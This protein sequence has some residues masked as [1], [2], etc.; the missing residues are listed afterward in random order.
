MFLEM[1]CIQLR[2]P[3][4]A[5]PI[6]SNIVR[7]RGPTLRCSGSLVNAR[8]ESIHARTHQLVL[9]YVYRIPFRIEQYSS[10][11]QRHCGPSWT[12]GDDA[13]HSQ[14]CN[15]LPCVRIATLRISEAVRCASTIYNLPQRVVYHTSANC[16][17]LHTMDGFT[18]RPYIKVSAT[19]ASVTRT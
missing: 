5:I 1:S 18:Q 13:L 8:C 11:G 4:D 3:I 2:P 17:R 7:R 12:Y 10:N 19:S 15:G 14:L 9:Q 16:S 6:R